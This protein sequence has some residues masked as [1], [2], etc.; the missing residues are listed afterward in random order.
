MGAR[1]YCPDSKLNSQPAVGIGIFQRPGSNS[2]DTAESVRR[3]MDNLNKRFPQGLEY[4][5]VFDTTSFLPGASINAVLETL[6]EAMI[7]VGVGGGDLS[8][9][10]GGHPSFPPSWPCQCR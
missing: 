5:I 4:R 3:T 1:D 2:I 7:L 8:A 9:K 10:H 6:V